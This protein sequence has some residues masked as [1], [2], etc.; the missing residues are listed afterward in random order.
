MKWCGNEGYSNFS[1]VYQEVRNTLSVIEGS[2]ENAILENI[3]PVIH[4]FSTIG[5]YKDTCDTIP[6][7][8]Q[9]FQTNDRIV[10]QSCIDEPLMERYIYEANN[11]TEAIRELLLNS[12]E[13]VQIRPTK[14]PMLRRSSSYDKLVQ[15]PKLSMTTNGTLV[16][17]NITGQRTPDSKKKRRG[18]FFS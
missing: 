6:E 14:V 17:D 16:D 12:S 3:V 15:L 4:L 8:L 10:L 11:R 7:L 1:K 9:N 5:Q 2:N 18:I 13:I